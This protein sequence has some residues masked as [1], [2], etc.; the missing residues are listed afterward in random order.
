MKNKTQIG[1]NRTGIALSPR[2][3]PEMIRAATEYSPGPTDGERISTVRALYDSQALP[4]GTMPP[5]A[6]LK[7]A[8]VTALEMLKGNKALVYMDKLGDRLGFERSGARLY[9]ALIPRL[10]A[11]PNWEGGPTRQE[12]E[13]IYSDE[14]SHFHLMRRCIEELGGD[15]TVQTPSA[16]VSA[17]ASLGV[18]QVLGDPRISLRHALHGIMVAE[19]VDNE[20][21][22][23]LFELATSLGHREHAE[24][25]R[26]ALLAEERH[27]ARVR[28]WLRAAVLSEANLELEEQPGDGQDSLE[29]TPLH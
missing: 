3:G 5:P 15:P 8:S 22:S 10:Q 28:G 12:L 29:N 23:A 19:L 17:T 1:M 9:E 14:L 2:M 13:E 20:G 21:W 25:F 18:V 4:I 27:L 16:D 11:G 24:Q 26:V 6:S 7:E